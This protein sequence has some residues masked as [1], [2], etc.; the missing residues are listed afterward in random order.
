MQAVAHFV[1]TFVPEHYE[2][3]LDL[4]R[5]TK[6]FSGRVV[7]TG[8][9]KAEK[10]SLHPKRDFDHRNSRSSRSSSSIYG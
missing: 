9:A 8:Q 6:T 10:I 4:S 3:F 7:I 2:V 1:E 5:K